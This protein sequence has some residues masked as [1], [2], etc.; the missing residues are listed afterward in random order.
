M[1]NRNCRWAAVVAAAALW[2]GA[3]AANVRAQSFG[4]ELHN[5]LMPASGGM[6]GVSIARP[7]DLQSALNGNPATLAQFRGTQF[8]FGGAWAEPTYNV[9]HAGGVLPN[10]TSYAAKSEAEGSSLANIGVTQDFSA[11]GLP[12]TTG[13]GLITAGG[14]GVSFRDVPQSNG[15]SAM[16]QTLEVVAGAGVKLTDRLA[17]GANVMI[18]SSTVDG[19]FV[20]LTAA[21]YDYALRGSLGLNYDAGACTTLGLYYQTKQSF[22]FDNAVFLDLGPGIDNVGLDLALDLPDNVGFGIANESFMDG[23]LL[24]AADVLYKQWD[25]A[26]FF[27]AIYDN[28]WVF[29]VGAQYRLSRHVRL[30]A[31]YTYAENAMDPNP[32]GAAG[33]ISPPGAVAAIQYAQAQFAAINRHRVSVGV[34]MRDVLPGVD[35]DLLA[36]G[37]FD[38]SQAFGSATSASVESYWVGMGM[39]WRFG[40]GCFERLPVPDDWCDA[41]CCE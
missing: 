3:T 14:G 32:G 19:P 37:M 9:T 38:E 34:G 29:Q 39:T 28:Q 13:L 5:T 20:G 24:L 25:N 41:G 27:R 30:R 11:F 18:G 26:D 35:V 10:V 31:G 40:R 22:N 33:G 36:G 2:F 17:V 16:L 12:I 6:A 4:V 7:Q 15:T 8:S 23:N 21:A 1:S